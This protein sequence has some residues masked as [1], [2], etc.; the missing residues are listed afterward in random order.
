[1][2]CPYCAEEVKDD[3]VVCKHCH[4][5]LFVVKPLIDKINQMG[6]RLALVEDE[7]EHTGAEAGAHTRRLPA[8][9]HNAGLTE[10]ESVALIYIVLAIAYFLIVVHFD[11][12]LIYLK[13]VSIAVPLIIGLLRR[14]PERMALSSAL[15]FGFMV[16][17]AV[18][19]TSAAVV[20]E[21]DKVPFLPK[22][23]Y[24]WRE[25]AYYDASVA[26]GYLTGVFLRLTLMAIYVPNA[27]PNKTIEWIAHFIVEQFGEGKRKFTLKAVRSMVSS[28][29]GFA[30]AVISV[31]TG[32]WEYLK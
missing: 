32:L 14:V 6:A 9:R 1:M 17:V 25:L 28:L 10:L 27:K 13:F 21:V 4:R 2:R 12:K 18:T 3:A 5:E 30:S 19:A 31:V 20:S 29:L 8:R 7:A 22:D 16:A 11:L 15:I 24:E 26:F 23:A